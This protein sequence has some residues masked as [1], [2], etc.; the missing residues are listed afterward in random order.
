[1]P[2]TREIFS[3]EFR[4]NSDVIE[5]TQQL[6]MIDFE[7]DAAPGY[8]HPIHSGKIDLGVENIRTFRK[9]QYIKQMQIFFNLDGNGANADTKT[10]VGTWTT[11]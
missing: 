7:A 2:A 5:A 3:I 1:M 10:N 8:K 6:W 9:S 11:Y 4:N